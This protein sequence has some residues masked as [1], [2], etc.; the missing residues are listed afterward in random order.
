VAILAVVT[1]IENT[2]NIE[3]KAVRHANAHLVSGFERA[4][5]VPYGVACATIGKRMQAGAMQ[6]PACRLLDHAR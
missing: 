3:L 2:V 4:A 1:S 6:L 5:I